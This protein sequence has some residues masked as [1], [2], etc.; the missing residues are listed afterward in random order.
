MGLI[1]GG[2]HGVRAGAGPGRITNPSKSIER[3]RF[4]I[5]AHQLIDTAGYYGPR[6]FER[7]WLRKA[8]KN[9]HLTSLWAFNQCSMRLVFSD[10]QD[11]SPVEG[12]AHWQRDRELFAV[13][14]FAIDNHRLYLLTHSTGPIPDMKFEE[15][16][17]TLPA[18]FS[19]KKAKWRYTRKFPTQWSSPDEACARKN[20]KP[21]HLHPPPAAASL[22]LC[23]NRK[24]EGMRFAPFCLENQ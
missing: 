15:D 7:K 2:G 9:F 11:L 19:R 22:L 5:A 3:A 16:G 10:R 13:P 21:D 23:L 18:A 6:P 20:R 8:L 1:I 14:A 24:I 4:A 12:G 17:K